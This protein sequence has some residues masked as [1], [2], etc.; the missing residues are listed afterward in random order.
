MIRMKL[1]CVIHTQSNVIQTIHCHV[2]LKYFFSILPKC[3]FVIVMHAH[4]IDISQGSTETHLWCGGNNNNHIY[5]KLSA[6][7]DTERILKIG[8]QLVKIWT[9]VKWHVFWPTL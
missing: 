4:F 9:K 6:E 1:D 2:G 5:H 7:C 3:L 8:Q